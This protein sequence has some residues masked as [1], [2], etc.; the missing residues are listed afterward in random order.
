MHVGFSP[1]EVVTID[2]REP[3]DRRRHRVA[4]EILHVTDGDVDALF[5]DLAVIHSEVDHQLIVVKRPVEMQ[6]SEQSGACDGSVDG[7]VRKGRYARCA[8]LQNQRHGFVDDVTVRVFE[9]TS[10][11]DGEDE[12]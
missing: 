8:V 7:L 12:L 11:V 1:F 3:C 2:V 10:V 5:V 4:V 6:R 9:D